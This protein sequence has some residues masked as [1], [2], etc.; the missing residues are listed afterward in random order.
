MRSVLWLRA[1]ARSRVLV[2]ILLAASALW[3]LV[4]MVWAV[5]NSIKT[6]EDTFRAGAVV[7]FL[8]FAP[9]L[10]SWRTVLMDPGV[11][12]ALLSS[13]VVSSGTTLLVLAVSLPAAYSL[14]RFDFFVSSRDLTLW[15]LSQRVLPPAVMLVP[16]YMMMVRF[17]L[18][19]TW[20]GLIISY[21]TFSL[22]FGVV[23]MRDVFR[24]VSKEIE[25][26]AKVEGATPWQIFL[27]IAL[28]L[29]LDGIVVTAINVF[30]F[31]W[32]EAL[33]SS[34]FTSLNAQTFASFI[35]ASRGTRD[36]NF[37]LAAANTLLAIGPP[38]ILSFFFQ[39]YLA[40]GLS[41]G[42]IKG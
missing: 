18:I 4:P 30:A 15:F 41:L 23:I 38:V 2:Y 8:Q 31:G 28:P 42:A 22:A 1:R 7:P 20:T 36:I 5:L 9:T 12:H 27:W 26:A 17:R 32:N 3:V 19:D 37:N 6:L 11:V 34:A 16:F 29:S 35:L 13:F 39:R 10:S 33:F 40:R 14:A 25:E 21:S 24:D